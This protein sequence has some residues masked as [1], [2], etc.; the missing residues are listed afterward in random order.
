VISGARAALAGVAM[1]TRRVIVGV[2]GVFAM[3]VIPDSAEEAAVLFGIVLLAGGFV[4][5]SVLDH[6]PAIA[7]L[8]LLVPGA[9]Y[10]AIGLGLTL[11][12]GR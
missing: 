1:A 3:L 12:R 2:A 5:W 9:L 11:R 10:V 7:A 8:A 6:S 4:A